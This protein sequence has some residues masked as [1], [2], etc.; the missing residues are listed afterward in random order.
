MKNTE[1]ERR[2]HRRRILAL[3]LGAGAL[4]LGATATFAAWTDSEWVF[5]GS[6]ADAAG[7]GTST[8][9]VEQS[10]DAGV[11]WGEFESADGANE[12]VFPSALA[13]SPGDSAYAAV[14]L[15]TT[16]DS[17]AGTVTL[18][19]A[20]PAT[21]VQVTGVDDTDDLLFDALDVRVVTSTSSFTCNLAAFSSETLIADGALNA[22]G[23]SAAQ[24][25]SA[26]GGSTQYY[27]FEITLP[28]PLVPASGYTVDDYMGR[29]VAP[30]WEFAAES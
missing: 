2:P 15:R 10:T 3:A 26:A 13:L 7:I 16:A 24:S 6:G 28:D 8:F 22:T 21:A 17:I 23:G 11:S 25:L 1:S 29:A 18:Q 5:G 12:M 4:G 20:D 30:L 9:E 14:Q 27:C 19:P